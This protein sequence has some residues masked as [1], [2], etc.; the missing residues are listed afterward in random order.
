MYRFIIFNLNNE[1]YFD[2]VMY[3]TPNLKHQY[4]Y[5]CVCSNKYY[6]LLKK[7]NSLFTFLFGKYSYNDHGETYINGSLYPLITLKLLLA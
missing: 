4:Y 6:C 1:M 7:K 5:F 2:Y 3:Y